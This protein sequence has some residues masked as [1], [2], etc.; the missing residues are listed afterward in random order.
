MLGSDHKRIHSW[1]GA[2]R[3][4]GSEL[5]PFCIHL[6]KSLLSN[7]SNGSS[8]LGEMEPLLQLQRWQRRQK[9][10]LL[11][12]RTMNKDLKRQWHRPPRRPLKNAVIPFWWTRAWKTFKNSSIQPKNSCETRWKICHWELMSEL[13]WLPEKKAAPPHESVFLSLLTW[14]SQWLHPEEINPLF[15]WFKDKSWE[16]PY[17]FEDDLLYKFYIMA[18]FVMLNAIGIILLLT[19]QQ[20]ESFVFYFP[21]KISRVFPAPISTCGLPTQ[22]YLSFWP[23]WFHACGWPTSGTRSLIPTTNPTT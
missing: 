18:S 3:L 12:L 20:Y 11:L 21:S 14:S 16:A 8:R 22:S 15:L 6:P 7:F 9:W 17:C 2:M 23:W 10:L 1:L 5:R 13:N 4:L 19:Q